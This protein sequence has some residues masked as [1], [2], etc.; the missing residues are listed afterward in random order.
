M[1]PSSKKSIRRTLEVV[2]AVSHGDFEKRILNIT[3]TGD[4][5]EL[6]HA[7][8]DMIDRCDA[9]YVNHKLV[10][11]TLAKTNIF[12]ASSKPVWRDLFYMLQKL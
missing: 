12:V 4:M 11:T 6:M 8:N 9:I 2:Q 7:I 5:G 3:E 10:P 1:F